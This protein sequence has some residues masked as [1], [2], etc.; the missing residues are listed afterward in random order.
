M[1]D[2]AGY[3][4]R[5]PIQL[6]FSDIDRLDHVNNSC[7]HNYCELGRVKYFDEV[8]TGMIEWSKQGF[9]LARTEIDHREPLFLN[10]EVFCYTRISRLGN[11]SITVHNLIT[12]KA[13]GVERVSAEIKGI[14]VAMDYSRNESMTVPDQWRN[15]I[16]DFESEL[17]E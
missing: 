3:K 5:I 16:R 13:E 9:I 4:H 12:K 17:E 2:P 8:L 15:A 14:L 6:R 10:D 11:K 1:N 7:Y